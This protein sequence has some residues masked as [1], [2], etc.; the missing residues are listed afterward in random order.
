MGGVT[1]VWFRMPATIDEPHVST[2]A[3]HSMGMSF[4]GHR[5]AVV[6]RPSGL[7]E[8][9]DIAPNTVFVTCDEPYD[10]VDVAEP[11]EGVEFDIAPAIL[12]DAAESHGVRLAAATTNDVLPPDPVF[13]ATAV[14]LRQHAVGIAPLEPLEG[15]GLM[16]ALLSH[17]ACEHLGGQPPRQNGRPLDGRRLSRVVDYVDA[18]LD[19][20]LSVSGLADVAS[21]STNH[22]HTAFR[23]ATGLTPHHFV[24]ARRVERAVA[25]LKAGRTREE[26]AR[27]VGYTAGHAFRRALARF[28]G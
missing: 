24:T 18:H 28:G 6:Q 27:A 26:A 2:T 16:L 15:D 23:R 14:R 10:W 9:M 21:M 4:T 20:R 3:A 11:Y 5:R 19:A 13:W 7:R 12:R 25:L 17:F 22:F 8:A 1:A